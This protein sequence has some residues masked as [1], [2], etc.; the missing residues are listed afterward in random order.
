M[1]DIGFKVIDTHGTFLL[2]SFTNNALSK[3]TISFIIFA[4]IITIIVVVFFCAACN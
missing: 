3:T 2:K 4:A 1:L